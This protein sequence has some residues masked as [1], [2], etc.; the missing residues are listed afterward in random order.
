MND[1]RTI[2]HLSNDLPEHEAIQ[3]ERTIAYLLDELPEPEALKFEEDCFSQPEWPELELQSAEGDLIQAYIKNE[4]SPERRRRFEENYH[5][6][7]ARIDKVLVVR[8]TL[9]VLCQQKPWTQ[10]V[11]AF[12][13]SLFVVPRSPV[14]R[15]ATLLLTVGLGATLLW[16]SFRPVPPR[17]FANINLSISSDSRG[18]SSQVQSVKLPLPEDALRISLALPELAPPDATYR[19]EWGD[20]RDP[21]EDLAVENPGANPITVVIPAKKLTPGQYTLKLFRKN[22]NGTEDRVQGNYFFNVD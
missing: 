9:K 22:P 15:L 12:V 2:T 4:L 3:Y 20:R 5:T 18:V 14:P 13:K 7:T 1:E 10:R 6:T 8:A 16:F 19:V 21:I 11:L 17:T